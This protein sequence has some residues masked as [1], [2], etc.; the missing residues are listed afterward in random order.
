M[1]L[2]QWKFG[3]W[4]SKLESKN[5]FVYMPACYNAKVYKASNTHILNLDL[6]EIEM[7]SQIDDRFRYRYKMKSNIHRNKVF[8]ELKRDQQLR[9]DLNYAFGTKT[10]EVSPCRE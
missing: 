5:F 6:L 4:D 3:P 7:N 1:Y 10:M 8:L 9:V 2:L